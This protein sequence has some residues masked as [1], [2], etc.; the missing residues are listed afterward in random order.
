MRVGF[1]I[2]SD[3]RVKHSWALIDSECAVKVADGDEIIEWVIDDG[4]DMLDPALQQQ[5][6]AKCKMFQDTSG[7][8]RTRDDALSVGQAYKDTLKHYSYHKPAEPTIG[9]EI[10][11]RSD[12]VL[13]GRLSGS[14]AFPG[15]GINAQ[16]HGQLKS[17]TTKT[18]TPL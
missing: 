11:Y 8:Y 5:C 1:L 9:E 13:A 4:R 17:A 7:Q 14:T 2:D 12:G 18:L 6:I 15:R 16:R 3:G 10:L